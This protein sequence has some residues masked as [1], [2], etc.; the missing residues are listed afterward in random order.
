MKRVQVLVVIPLLTYFKRYTVIYPLIKTYDIEFQLSCFSFLC[1]VLAM[2]CLCVSYLIVDFFDR[3]RPV[4]GLDP[5]RGPN[6]SGKS[7]FWFATVCAVGLIPTAYLT[8]K[9]GEISILYVYFSVAIVLWLLAN[10]YRKQMLVGNLVIA[11]LS[12][13][14]PLTVLLDINQLQ[15]FYGKYALIFD[16]ATYSIIGFALFVFLTVLVYD[17]ICDIAEFESD[18]DYDWKTLPFVMGDRFTKK[19]IIAIIATIIAALFYA[20]IKYEIFFNTIGILFSFFYL[21]FLLV[22]PLL[23]TIWKIHK[24]SSGNDYRS[25]GNIIKLVIL[26]G[27]VLTC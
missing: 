27:F 15:G 16:F 3:S 4:S 22:I 20:Y 26:A 17:M 25:A 5:D 2:M 23:F 9:T 13:L 11:I 18:V 6:T 1:L 24:A 19:V 8:W 14:I 7:F 21:L 12:A 10:V